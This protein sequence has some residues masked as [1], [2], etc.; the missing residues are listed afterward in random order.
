MQKLYSQDVKG[1]VSDFCSMIKPLKKGLWTVSVIVLCH[2]ENVAKT[3][4]LTKGLKPVFVLPMLIKGNPCFRVCAGLFTTRRGASSKVKSVSLDG[5]ESHPFPQLVA[6]KAVTTSKK[7]T[8]EKS[9]VKVPGAAK[10]S[11]KEVEKSATAASPGAKTAVEA[12]GH[13]GSE[14]VW[15]PVAKPVTEVKNTTP[16]KPDGKFEDKTGS[17][18][19]AEKAAVPEKPLKVDVIVPEE[20]KAPPEKTAP[21]TVKTEPDVVSGKQQIEEPKTTSAKS[22]EEKLPAYSPRSTGLSKPSREGRTWFN[23]GL[24]ALGRGDMR[25]AERNFQEALKADPGRP[26]I[27]NDLGIV[28]LRQGRYSESEKLFRS[29]LEKS[30]NYAR[31]RLNLSGALW[32]LGRRD[33][34]IAEAE[35]AVKLDSDDV[36][37][38]LTLAS[39]YLALGETDKGAVAAQRALLLD[40]GNARART[41]FNK[42]AEKSTGK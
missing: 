38:F 22:P 31:A 20:K 8:E 17:D 42:C 33:E 26:E 32:G 15:K 24:A 11:E 23:K 35:R 30:P 13:A 10:Q 1:A 2:E 3:V 12:V 25:E 27:L 5:I 34:A 21:T 36:N 19:A 28:R 14:V 9:S 6:C 37:G 4:H 7:S 16:E 18:A 40:P 39:F 41:I 29:A